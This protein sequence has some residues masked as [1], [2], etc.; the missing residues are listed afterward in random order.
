MVNG[1]PGKMATMVVKALA[2]DKDQRYEIIPL[3]FTG[4]EIIESYT[5]LLLNNKGVQFDFIKPSDRLE[6]RH[7]ISHKWPGVIM[8][9]F[10]LPDATNENCD[11]YCQNG[12]PFVMGTTGG[13][14]DLLTETIIESAISAVISPNMSIP[15]VTMMSMIEYAA[16]TFP[17]ALKGFRLC[18]DESHQAGKKDKSGTAHKIGENLKLLGVD[19][20]GIDSIND[21]RDTVRQILMGVP[22]A[23]LGGH[24]YHN[25]RLLSPDDTVQLG[26]LHNVNG[27]DTYVDGTLKAIDFLA[28]QVSEDIRGKC[29]SMIDVLKG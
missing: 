24:A 14:R 26:F 17:D 19:Y 3:S 27:R 29:F 6:R 1:L 22:K 11:F 2:H 28:K 7:E 25:Y 15:I 8:V 20:Q 13:N 23:D 12:W 21:I 9:D 4:P 16:T 18:I 5:V 10:T